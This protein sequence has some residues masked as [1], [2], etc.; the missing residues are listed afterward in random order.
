M[1]KFNKKKLTSKKALIV[2]LLLASFLRLWK[3]SEVPVSLF[4]DELDVGYHAYSILKT[5]KDYSGNPWPLHFKSLAE[6]RTPLYLYSAVPTVAIFGLSPL[7]VRLPAAFFGV[8]GVWGFYLLTKKLLKDERLA[9]VSS[10]LLAISPWHLQYSR[11]AFE[12]TMLLAVLIF[13]FYFFL[14]ALEQNGKDLWISGAFFIITPL[15]YSS[16]KLFTPIFML[17]IAFLWRNKLFS[18]PKNALTKALVATITLGLITAYAT[19]F[20]GGGQRFGYISVFTDPTREMEIGVAREQDA[21]AIGDLEVGHTPSTSEKIFHNKVWFWGD[22]VLTNYLESF[23]FSFL[24]DKGDP[25]LRHSIQ[26]MG[27]F[28]AIELVAFVVG[29]SMF[30]SSKKVEKRVK[31]LVAFWILFGAL[32]SAI[33]REGGKHATRLILMLPPLLLLISFGVTKII[34]AT[35]WK[36]KYSLGLI[37]AGL[38]I[39]GVVFYQHKYWIHN[40][41]YSERWWHAGFGEAIRSVKEVDK[42]YERVFISMSGEPAWTFFSAW[43]QYD[44]ASWQKEYPIGNDV[45]QEGFGD[46]SHTSKFYFG[47]PQEGIYSLGRFIGSGDLYLANA[48]EVG[49]NLIT[50]PNE[51]TPV[52]LV[53]L[54]AIAYPSGEPA[55]YLF[56]GI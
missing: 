1:G 44:P 14:R 6:W 30:F 38:L 34:D 39:L 33:T 3:L 40:L 45:F 41:T 17:F 23:S 15:I 42:N 47:S 35:L 37:Y 51:G 8:L 27:Q 16:A 13:G 53:L 46:I 24:F 52:G 2:I 7:G 11:A 48:S 5:G 31:K 18:L 9:L 54:K 32:P 49:E 28:Y 50:N 55:F 26:D 12:V 25:N 4:G 43:Y 10:F 29:L 19:L 20:S 56:S 22:R 36:K 21:R